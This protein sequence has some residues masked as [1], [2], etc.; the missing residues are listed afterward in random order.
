[1]RDRIM[2][3]NTVVENPEDGGRVTLLKGDKVPA[4]AAEQV[5]DHLVEGSG[6]TA[7]P[8]RRPAAETG[9]QYP[10]AKEI[11][12][13]VVT[14]LRE[15]MEAHSADEDQTP[16]VDADEMPPTGGKGSGIEAWTAYADGKG[17][18]YPEGANRDEVIAAVQAHNA[19]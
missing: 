19:E 15:E 2:A 10:T 1:M 16:P 12:T 6:G 13:E 18:A 14:L 5:G 11:A 7:K 8:V 9:Q 4:W 17:I 3:E